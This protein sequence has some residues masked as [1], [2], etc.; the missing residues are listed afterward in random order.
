M[1]LWFSFAAMFYKTFL[2]PCFIKLLSFRIFEHFATLPYPVTEFIK[3]RSTLHRQGAILVPK[4]GDPLS[5]LSK[6]LNPFYVERVFS[7]NRIQQC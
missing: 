5:V 6:W 1:K 4:Q 3:L 7:Q 2:L